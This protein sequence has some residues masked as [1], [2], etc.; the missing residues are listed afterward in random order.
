VSFVKVGCFDVNIIMRDKGENMDWRAIF[1]LC[2]NIR[3]QGVLS[4]GL[5]IVKKLYISTIIFERK[6]VDLQICVKD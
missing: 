2:H 4:F 3:N 5:N 1:E 6:Q